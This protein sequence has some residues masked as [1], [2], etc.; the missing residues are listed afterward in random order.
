[1]KTDQLVEEIKKEFVLRIC[2]ESISKII[3]CINIISDVD[4][5]FSPNNNIPCIANLVLHLNGNVRQW[6]LN[7]LCDLEYNRVRENEFKRQKKL[8]KIDLI[9]ILST[10]STDIKENIHIINYNLILNKKTIQNIYFV[11]GYS[12]INHVTEHFS[13]H[14]GQ[15]VTLTK[16]LKDS[17]LGFYNG[18]NIN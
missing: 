6:F 17:N 5:H 14:T 2:D 11:S 7:G 1:L 16:I 13:Y 10:L 8:T 12:I 4:L 9:H 15:I 18:L 3:S